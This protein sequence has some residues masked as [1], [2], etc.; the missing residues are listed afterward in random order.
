[1]GSEEWTDDTQPLTYGNHGW[2]GI[3]LVTVQMIRVDHS[4]TSD[5]DI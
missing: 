1:M 4:E 5:S 2:N 3:T